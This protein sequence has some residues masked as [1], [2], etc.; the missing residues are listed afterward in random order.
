MTDDRPIVDPEHIA[1]LPTG[2][3]AVV[4]IGP[5]GETRLWLMSPNLDDHTHGCSCPDHA[6][7]EQD[8]PLPPV[9]RQRLNHTLLRCGAPTLA[10]GRPC[11]CP[12]ARV[13][14]RCTHHRHPVP[15]Q[16][17]Q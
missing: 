1:H 11:R 6:P 9:Y 10:T 13:G 5:D 4:A 14:D 2:G 3:H 12:V 8:G 7:H 17:D 15:S 16:E